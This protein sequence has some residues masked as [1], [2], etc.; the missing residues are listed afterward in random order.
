MTQVQQIIEDL[1]KSWYFR[2]WALLWLVFLI[3]GFVA[4]GIL[5]N[6]S[7]QTTMQK[8]GKFTFVES[9]SMK[10]PRFHFH[11]GIYYSGNEIITNISCMYHN[12]PVQ[13]GLCKPFNGQTPS[14]NNCV[15]VFGDT[16]VVTSNN[17]THESRN[18]GIGCNITTT[19]SIN[20]VGTMIAFAFEGNN[21]HVSEQDY[22]AP[23]W[24][25]P[26]SN[27]VIE[28][29]REIM[30]V[31]GVVGTYWDRQ[32]F[33]FSDVSVA[34]TYQIFVAVNGFGAFQFSTQ[35]LYTG[36]RALG[37]IGGFAYFLVML[38]TGVMILLGF[39]FVNESS[40]LRASSGR[41]ATSGPARSAQDADGS[42]GYNRLI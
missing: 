21:T 11:T 40:F 15:S 9:K 17:F 19:G 2:F 6:R 38:Q 12:T 32:L 22:H 3:V 37:D 34:G 16:V 20:Q 30:N 26:T 7:A 10:L 29:N 42:D 4:L 27:A 1:K 28:L 36:W 24:I 39:C 8:D 25:A 33:Y 5:A 13:T 41:S 35:N 31:N 18:L 14:I 23:L